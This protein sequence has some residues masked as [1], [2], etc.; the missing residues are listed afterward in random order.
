MVRIEFMDLIVILFHSLAFFTLLFCGIVF[1]S[2]SRGKVKEYRQYLL[3]MGIFFLLYG[4]SRIVMFSFEMLF[5]IDFVWNLSAS[6][7]RLIFAN[8]PDIVFVHEIIWRITSLIGNVGLILL[9]YIVERHILEKKLK[10]IPTIFMI[11]SAIPALILGAGQQKD[12]LSIFRIV[13]YIGNFLLILVP[14]MYLYL[15]LKTSGRT[16]KRAISATIGMTTMFAGVTINSSMGKTVFESLGGIDGLKISYILYG[17]FVAIGVLITLNSVR[18]GS[19]KKITKKVTAKKK[20][21]YDDSMISFIKKMG[22]DFTRPG[23]LTEEQITFYKEQKICLVCKSKILRLNYVCPECDALY[24]GKCSD[25]LSNLENACWVCETAFDETKPIH[26]DEEEEEY[27]V[28]TET[29][30][31]P[32]VKTIKK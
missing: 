2:K 7:F 32:E 13:M 28:E 25:V 17:T 29:H 24:C 3:G 30:K 22:I 1:I 4:I 21:V 26:L 16:K 18:E 19:R 23:E 27:L 10:Y 12:E 31:T 8:N 11:F 14:L 6:D 15:G 9:M 20:E 5:P